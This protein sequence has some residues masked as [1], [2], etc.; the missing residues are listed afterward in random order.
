MNPH[1][2]PAAVAP[3]PHAAEGTRTP[4]P[5]ELSGGSDAP[6]HLDATLI[7]ACRECRQLEDI[8]G[9]VER[10]GRDPTA[11]QAVGLIFRYCDAFKI[12]RGG[13]MEE[14]QI[15]KV[16]EL[17]PSQEALRVRKGMREIHEIE[18]RS[19]RHT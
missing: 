1:P 16:Q 6:P 11:T 3:A 15:R 2:P 14:H 10:L 19:G 13:N 4:V 7:E 12:A 8:P 18:R 5:L 9:C 17:R